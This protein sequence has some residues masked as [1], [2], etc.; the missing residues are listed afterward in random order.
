M[1]LPLGPSSRLSAINNQSV[2]DS[3]GRCIRT[4]PQ[5]GRGDF[6]GFSHP[7]NWLL[8]DYRLAAFGS[9]AGKALHHR[10]IDDSRADRVDADVRCR[11]VECRSF[12]EANHAVLCGN[13]RGPTLEAFYPGTRG[14]IYDRASSLFEHQWNFV[15]HAQEY[16]SEVNVHNSIP[17]CFRNFGCWL[18][19]IFDTGVVKCDVKPP[20]SFN[21]LFK[22][23]THV[24]SSR[25]IASDSECASTKFLDHARCLLVGLFRDVSHHY[26]RTFASKCQSRSSADTASCSGYKCHFPHVSSIH[27]IRHNF[28]PHGQRRALIARRS[29]IAR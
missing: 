1:L 13:V 17:F 6:L 4:E 5:N 26:A 16:A 15:L 12:R 21:G 20:E 18:D 27:F 25:N 7:S 9:A 8:G 3:E 14:C 2:P 19:L 11:I 23:S 22:R 24:I 28:S 10:R 29:S